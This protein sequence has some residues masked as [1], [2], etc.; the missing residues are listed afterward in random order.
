M[1]TP[2]YLSIHDSESFFTISKKDSKYINAAIFSAIYVAGIK[3]PA[4]R[5]GIAKTCFILAAAIIFMLLYSC[6]KETAGRTTCNTI[7]SNASA[8]MSSVVTTSRFVRDNTIGYGAMICAPDDASSLSF[9]LN[10]ADELGV[11]C[12]RSR[13]IVPGAG[14]VPT[15]N[16]KYKILLNFSSDYKGAPMPFVTD[17]VKY[18]SDLKSIL[19]TFTI[20]PVIAVIENEESN[21]KYFMGTAVQYISQ[22]KT[23]I[24][25]MHANKIKVANGGVTSVGLCYLVYQD[26]MSQGRVAEAKDFQARTNLGVNDPVTQNRGAFIDTLLKSYATS[27]LDYVNFHWKGSSPDPQALGEAIAYLKKATGKN[28]ISNELG[29]LDT[30]PNTLLTHVQQCTNNGLPYITWY[31][32]NEDL[33]KRS[34]SLQHNDQSLT[35]NGVTYKNYLR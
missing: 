29:Q 30:D 28:I 18:K 17:L 23:A 24:D 3:S 35:P 6:K 31:S 11:S 15:L 27:K 4:F 8:A 9:Q 16:S 12:L 7:S 21:L 32:P 5:S 33:G 2:H 25:V 20:M 10:V 1:D 34:T 19:S 26:Y 14:D 13:T 22:L